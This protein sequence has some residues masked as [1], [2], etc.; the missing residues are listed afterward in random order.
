[1]LLGLWYMW[2][3]SKSKYFPGI[4]IP[5]PRL[6]AESSLLPPYWPTLLLHGGKLC[7][8]LGASSLFYWLELPGNLKCSFLQGRASRVVPDVCLLSSPF[9]KLCR[10]NW[11]EPCFTGLALFCFTDRR[12]SRLSLTGGGLRFLGE[13]VGSSWSRYRGEVYIVGGYSG[14]S[15]QY[16]EA[17]LVCG[18]GRD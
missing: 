1:M 9:S 6:R 18:V 2:Q 17:S 11:S 7:L 13:S 14:H 16:Q 12:W 8:R 4:P 15:E 10:A 5:A 3:R